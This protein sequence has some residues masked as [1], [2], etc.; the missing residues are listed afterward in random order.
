LRQSEES[1]EPS[2]S[3]ELTESHDKIN[4]P[5]RSTDSRD[6]LSEVIVTLR[7][8]REYWRDI[9]KWTIHKNWLHRVHRTKK[10]KTKTQDFI[11]T[12]IW[13]L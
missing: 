1:V 11:K 3:G 7:N 6:L 2:S 13:C 5:R 9:Q 12:T 10:N 8:V 4:S